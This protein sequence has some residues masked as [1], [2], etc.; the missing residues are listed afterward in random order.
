LERRS[1]SAGTV[2]WCR[3]K[4]E[5][6]KSPSLGQRRGKDLREE[7]PENPR[8]L[9]SLRRNLKQGFTKDGAFVAGEKKRGEGK[10]AQTKGREKQKEPPGRRGERKPIERRTGDAAQCQKSA[11]KAGETN[12]KESKRGAQP[13]RGIS[14]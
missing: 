7:R 1:K 3:K 14:N 5:K 10:P 8:E 12:K 11:E 6:L 9:N 4:K 13:R 2:D